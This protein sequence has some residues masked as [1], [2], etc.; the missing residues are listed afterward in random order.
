[1]SNNITYKD[2][3][4]NYHSECIG[5]NGSATANA[6]LFAVAYAA[7]K[8]PDAARARR[9]VRACRGTAVMNPGVR[10]PGVFSKDDEVQVLLSLGGDVSFWADFSIE[11][12]GSGAFMTTPKCPIYAGVLL[13]LILMHV[14]DGRAV[15]PAGTQVKQVADAWT[16]MLPF[17]QNCCARERLTAMARIARE[18]ADAG[19]DLLIG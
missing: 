9:A 6:N 13:P 18:A 1:M 11:S 16:A 8:L 14:C 2:S 3:A 19:V 5:T 12:A 7:S 17:L 4:G 15:I 10:L